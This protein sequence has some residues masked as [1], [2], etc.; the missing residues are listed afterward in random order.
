MHAQRENGARAPGFAAGHGKTGYQKANV[1]ARTGLS[2][3][4]YHGMHVSRRRECL[5]FTP[6]GCPVTMLN[7]C[8]LLLFRVFITFRVFT[9]PASSREFG[10]A[11]NQWVPSTPDAARWRSALS[12]SELGGPRAAALLP[13]NGGLHGD[14]VRTLN[15]ADALLAA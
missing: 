1:R 9:T 10:A 12:S 8:T 3:P 5:F 13:M 2:E 4:T 7:V 14:M 6:A 11:T 15:N